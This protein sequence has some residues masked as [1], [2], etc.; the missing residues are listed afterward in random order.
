MVDER[1][2]ENHLAEAR[3]CFEQADKS[4]TVEEAIGLM[5]DGLEHLMVYLEENLK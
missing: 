2:P 4:D 1:E 3:L 5:L